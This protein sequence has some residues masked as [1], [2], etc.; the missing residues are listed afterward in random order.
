M[1]DG[2]RWPEARDLFLDLVDRDASERESLLTARAAVDP[3][4]AQWVRELLKQDDSLAHRPVE[5][6]RLG[7]YEI[8]RSIGRGGMGEVF[9]ARRADGEFEREV[10]IKRLH[11]GLATQ[12]LVRRFL[13]ERQTLARLDHEYV[14]GLIDGGTTE[15]GEPYLVMEYV[16][17]EPAD[18]YAA[19]LPL[20]GRLELFLRIGRAVA[21]AHERG[22]VHR[23]LKPSNILVRADGAP[24]LLDF[25]IAGHDPTTTPVDAGLG[26]PL[27][28]TG[29]RMFTPEYASPE[30]VRG[31]A[32]TVR[33]DVFALGVLLYE[34]ITGEKPWRSGDGQYALERSICEDEPTPPGRRA[35][36]PGAERISG[37]L[38]AIVLQCLAKRPEERYASVDAVCADV[39]RH[40]DDQPILAR[41][42]SAFERVAR[43]VRQRPARA[44]VALLAVILCG[45]AA[46]TW[47]N[48][49][50]DDRRR[51]ELRSAVEGRIATA[52]LHA[53]KGRVD[54]AL[55]ELEAAESALAQLPGETA[56]EAEVLSRKAVFASLRSDWQAVHGHVDR[57]FDLLRGTA[58]PSPHLVARLLNARA[59]ALQME[60]PGDESHEAYRVALEYTLA[61]V[62]PGDVLRMDALTGW[63]L[64]LRRLGREDEYIEGLERALAEARSI[65]DPR[66]QVL[67]RALNDMAV[68]LARAQRFD[69][70][71]ERYREALEILAWNHGESH[72]SFA[73]VRHNYASSLFR[74]GRIPESKEQFLRS[75]AVSRA[76]GH[77]GLTASCQQFLARIHYGE[78]DSAAAEA[79]VREA[80]DIRA[81]IGPAAALQES[82]CMHGIVLAAMGRTDEA[83]ELLVALF[84]SQPTLP[85]DLE[86][87]AR[88][89]LG[90][91]LDDTGDAAAA[92]PHL[93]RAL[94]LKRSFLGV[95]H[96]DCVEIARRLSARR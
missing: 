70:A 20:R 38:D 64:E 67:S 17:G 8:V 56:L 18:V 6:Q 43:R 24:R 62:P 28:R 3:E 30:Q 22:F 36:R 72:P 80:L 81:R 66:R 19:R 10:A 85:E 32:A 91:I 69:E 40:L 77:E 55:T 51:V 68:A 4:L 11:K 41:R 79:L 61:H 84:V 31:E 37:D 87:E 88:H 23:D 73:I 86:S 53:E 76:S 42:T 29:H 47:T 46:V 75:L 1:R 44:A 48:R 90:T 34:F 9:V 89:R 49:R 54:A 96:P 52:L 15:A 50:D 35:R 71:S 74:A 16:D 59:Y 12:D 92:R 95:D 26:E 27:T 25:G 57:S 13:R 39:R 60:Q 65:E 45:F 93:E 78:G 2:D 5:P 94:A 58:D 14:A 82:R 7:P 21:H 33:S 83:L 63:A